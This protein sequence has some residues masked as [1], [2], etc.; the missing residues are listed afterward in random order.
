MEFLQIYRYGQVCSR[1]ISI[2]P[3]CSHFDADV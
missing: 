3:V 2:E 1:T